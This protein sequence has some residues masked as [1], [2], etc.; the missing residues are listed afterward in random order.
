MSSQKSS[1]DNFVFVGSTP[2]NR[3][4]LADQTFSPVKTLCSQDPKSPIN[5]AFASRPLLWRN[6]TKL[7]SLLALLTLRGLFIQKPLHP[8]RR[9][10]HVFGHFYVGRR[11]LNHFVQ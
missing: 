6:F 2:S 11:K 10:I 8:P 1:S 7:F 4:R 3:Q 5:S 9:Y